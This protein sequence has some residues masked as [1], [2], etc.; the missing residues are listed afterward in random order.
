MKSIQTK[1]L[2]LILVVIIL[3]TA[4]IGGNSVYFV[5][6]SS[7][8]STAQIMNLICQEEGRNIDHIFHSIEQ[9]VKILAS[10]TIRDTDMIEVL[11]NKEL[12]E[13]YL[14]SLHSIVLATAESAEG[15]V[16]AY[17][18]FSPELSPPDT[19]LFYAK[20][21]VTGVFEEHETTDFSKVKDLEAE[22]FAWYTKPVREGKASW[23]GPYNNGKSKGLILTYVTPVYADHTLVGVA[24]MDIHISELMEIIDNIRVYETGHAALVTSDHRMI[25]HAYGDEEETEKFPIKD[26]EAWKFY[27][28]EAR[29]GRDMDSLFEFYNHNAQRKAAFIDLEAGMYL[30][31]SAPTSELDERKED[32]LNSTFMLMVVISIFCL[33]ISLFVSQGIVRPL[34]EITKASKQV[35]E[36]NL[37]VTLDCK[38]KDEVGEL[39]TSIQQ[40]VD[41]LR[42]YMERISDM[43]YTDTLTG[44]KSK[45]AYKEEEKKININIENGFTQLG[46]VMFDV[47]NLKTINDQYGHEAG[48]AYI[49]NGCRLICTTFKHSPVFRIG[50]DEFVAILTGKDLLNANY[51]MKQFYEKMNDKLNSAIKPEDMVSVSAGIALF[52]EGMDSELQDIFKRADAHMYKNKEKVKKG[53]PPAL[54]DT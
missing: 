19:G 25:Y 37:Q 8:Q 10:N 48:D 34:K 7:D 9:S 6:L 46:I 22:E 41:C 42:V 1:I 14:D 5:Q 35:A 53:L 29:K 23:I 40:T 36:G 26:L 11:K 16:A 31:V 2:V 44:V 32:L 3:C 21:D 39:A 15:A 47:N 45:A 17:V 52:K 27:M 33:L 12:R 50:G 49:L 13:E 18:H 54:E 24:G 38:S 51:L 20:K 28:D 30:M 43:A 4:V